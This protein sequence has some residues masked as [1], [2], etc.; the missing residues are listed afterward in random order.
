[1]DIPPPPSHLLPVIQEWWIDFW[2]SPIASSMR[3]TDMPALSRLFGMYDELERTRAAVHEDPPP[4][5]E[6]FPDEPN[7]D[8]WHRFA[9]WRRISAANGRLIASPKG[10]M[11]LNPL[12]RY[13]TT[14]SKDIMYLEDRFG[15][16]LRARQELGLNAIKAQ[17]LAEQNAQQREQRAKE[18][19]GHSDPIAA[20]L[21]GRE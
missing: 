12:L 7:N 15:F 14:L 2:Q 9:E 13:I 18:R 19:N 10:G 1:M 8:W 4:R 11:I 21:S 20:L 3:P 6:R 16:T 17:S 5:P